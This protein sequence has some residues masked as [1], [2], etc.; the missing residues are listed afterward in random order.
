M[1]IFTNGLCSRFYKQQPIEKIMTMSDAEVDALIDT[2]LDT[3]IE[4]FQERNTKP[5]PDWPTSTWN[6]I[7]NKRTDAIKSPVIIKKKKK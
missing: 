2:Y 3:Y 1:K 5:L 4:R 7:R 6:D